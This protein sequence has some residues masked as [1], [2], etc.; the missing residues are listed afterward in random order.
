MNVSSAR[1]LL[2]I[3][4]GTPL[5][6]DPFPA[7]QPFTEECVELVTDA[8]RSGDLFGMGGR[9]VGR[10]ETEY[11]EFYGARHAISVSS[12][13][14]AVHVALAAYDPEPGSEVITAPITDAG[15]IVPILAAGCVPVFAD[16]DSSYAMDPASIE[17]KITDRTV[18]IVVVH[19][20]G[21]ASDVRLIREIADRHGIALIEDCS[22]A[23]ATRLDGRY[24][25]MFGHV[26][27]FSLQQSKHLTTGDGGM[28][29]TDDPELAERMLLFRDKGWIRTRYGSRSY[30]GF[31][32]NYRMTE[33]QAA[34]GIPQLRTLDSVVRRRRDFA[35]RANSHFADVPGVSAFVPIEGCEASYWTYPFEVDNGDI[36]RFASAL[37]E[38]GIPTM[39]GFHNDPIYLSMSAL[40]DQ[41]TFG[42]SSYP[43]VEPFHEPVSYAPGL[44]PAAE[45]ALSR[46]IVFWLNEDMT[47]RD[48]DSVGLAVAKVARG[49]T[50]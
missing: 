44:C 28:A 26:G 20:F 24:V 50:A 4:G 30:D 40:R 46:L 15:T 1:E 48:A 16:V 10:F 34:V 37:A 41:K 13:T 49:L 21:G 8:V 19:L 36:H 22:Q 33:L 3:D 7:R 17:S 23:H 39:P 27:A 42:S 43:F 9:Y 47:E 6:T 29:I 38:E 11:A 5:R 32:M 25:G 18:A 45:A 31:G 35:I 2:A 14:A 12:G